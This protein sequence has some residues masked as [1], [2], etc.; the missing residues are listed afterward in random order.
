MALMT[1]KNTIEQPLI[2]KIT[3]IYTNVGAIVERMMKNAAKVKIKIAKYWNSRA[4]RKQVTRK[5]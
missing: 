4:T 2:N 5:R 1:P 3:I